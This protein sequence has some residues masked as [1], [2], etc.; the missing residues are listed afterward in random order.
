MSLETIRSSVN[1]LRTDHA[2]HDDPERDHAAEDAIWEAALR[3]IA[4]G[5]ADPAVVA[6]EALKTTGLDIGHWYA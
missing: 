2:A 6:A 5:C 1:Q 4:D 3:M